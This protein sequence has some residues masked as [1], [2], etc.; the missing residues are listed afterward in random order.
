MRDKGEKYVR[1]AFNQ[2]VEPPPAVD[3][4]LSDPPGL[5]VLLREERRM[6][7]VSHKKRQPS[8]TCP[9]GARRRLS[10]SL[11]EPLR[12]DKLHEP[13]ERLPRLRSD[14]TASLAERNGPFKQ[15]TN[16]DPPLFCEP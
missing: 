16:C 8:I 14:R 15:I 5:V 11:A 7:E 1:V 3:T 10:V 13:T 6:P 9:L 2:K 12:V 4:Q